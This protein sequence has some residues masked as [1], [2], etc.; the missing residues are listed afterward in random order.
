MCSE[1][2]KRSTGSSRRRAGRQAWSQS[3]G[4]TPMLVT[5]GSE[6]RAKLCRATAAIAQF[7]RRGHRPA[8]PGG[9][10]C[11]GDCFERVAKCETRA[12]CYAG[13]ATGRCA[14]S[15]DDCEAIRAAYAEWSSGVT[16]VTSGSPSLAPGVY[17]FGC[18][19]DDDCRL[20]PGHCDAGLDTCWMLG[21][22]RPI[23]D[24]LAALFQELGCAASTTCE[25]PPAGVSGACT[26]GPEPYDRWITDGVS[27]E[28]ACVMQPS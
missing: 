16:T 13:A 18:S 9:L 12:A 26:I 1:S 20:L 15:L 11:N 24:E 21:R 17:G 10:G 6:L 23:L 5:C 28:F 7:V 22:P 14:G 27:Y 8:H 4:R 3:R 25:C 19:S 2:S